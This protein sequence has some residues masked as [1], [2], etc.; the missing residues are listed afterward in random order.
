MGILLQN[1]KE[2][3]RMTFFKVVHHKLRERRRE[4]YLMSVFEDQVT[5]WESCLDPTDEIKAHDRTY[6]IIKD[7]LLRAMIERDRALHQRQQ[8]LLDSAPPLDNLDYDNWESAVLPQQHLLVNREEDFPRIK[9]PHSRGKHRNSLLASSDE[10]EYSVY[11]RRHEDHVSVQRRK[12]MD[13]GLEGD[14]G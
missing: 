7:K 4:V 1:N 12:L 10:D 6:K 9:D 5:K 11:Q 2:S 8:H 3:K 14:D 13:V